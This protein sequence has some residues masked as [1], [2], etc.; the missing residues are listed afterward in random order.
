MAMSD[1]YGVKGINV[2]VKAPPKQ[3]IR[4]FPSIYSSLASLVSMSIDGWF[5]QG[6][7]TQPPTPRKVTL[8]NRLG[9][10]V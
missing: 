5:N 2:E 4:P 10:W 3:P 1:H 7:E 6:I 8:I 9:N